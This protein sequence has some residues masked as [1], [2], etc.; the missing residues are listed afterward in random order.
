MTGVE[1]T[2]VEYP[3]V[4]VT[5]TILSTSRATAERLQ[6]LVDLPDGDDIKLLFGNG[7]DDCKDYFA[8]GILRP[9]GMVDCI[10]LKF[11]DQWRWFGEHYGYPKCCIDQFATTTHQDVFNENQFTGTGFMPCDKCVETS[12]PK[13]LVVIIGENRKSLI[14]YLLPVSEMEEKFELIVSILKQGK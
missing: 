1:I 6:P 10:I 7:P 4:E 13:D 5:G 12:S 3:I 11:E 2:V 14:P 9:D 8:L